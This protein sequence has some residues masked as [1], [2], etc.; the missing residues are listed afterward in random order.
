MPYDYFAVLDFEATCWDDNNNHEIIEFPT[1]IIDCRTGKEVDRIEQFVRPTYNPTVSDFCHQ[2]TTITQAQVDAGWSF[3]DAFS[4]H[5]KFMSKYPN[6]IF[7]TCGDWDLRT[8]LPRD[9]QANGI[10]VPAQYKKYINIKHVFRQAYP[11]AKGKG[12]PD[13][14]ARSGLEMTGTLHRGIDDCVNIARITV[15]LANMGA[16]D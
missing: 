8:M 9:A 11:D 4:A 14:L 2:L 3:V 13:M 16:L 6:S 12:L 7:V 1:V 10:E 15:H 5:Q